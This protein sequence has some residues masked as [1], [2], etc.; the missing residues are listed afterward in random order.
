MAW[1]KK[2]LT[3]REFWEKYGPRF[4]ET[5]RRLRERIAEGRKKSAEEKSAS[6]KAD[7]A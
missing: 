5:D 7:A 4:D 2:R 1:K 3:S 6:E